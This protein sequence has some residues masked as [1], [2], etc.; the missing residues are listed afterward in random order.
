MRVVSQSGVQENQE[1]KSI[2]ATKLSLCFSCSCF[3]VFWETGY[4]QIRGSIRFFKI[5]E[6]NL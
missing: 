3:W 1:K 2:T 6:S 5:T 4:Q